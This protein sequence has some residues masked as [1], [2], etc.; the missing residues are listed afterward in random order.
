MRAA[1]AGQVLVVLND[2]IHLAQYV[3]K[4]D[5]QLPG[6]FRSHPGPLGQ[7][8]GGAALL[9]YAPPPP[10]A[11]LAPGKEAAQA[12]QHRPTAHPAWL[13][14]PQYGHLPPAALARR[15]AIWPLTMDGQAPPEALLSQLDGLVL[16]GSGTGSLPA[17][18][19]EALAGPASD[20]G[21]AVDGCTSSR[22]GRQVEQAGSGGSGHRSPWT[23]RLPI[24]I[25]S[26]CTWGSNHDDFC[27]KGSRAKYEGRGF[28]LGGGYEQLNPL[29]ARVL[30]ALRLAAFGHA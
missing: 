28:V 3:F 18:V 2:S 26:R 29:Q 23:A 19:V 8:R 15:V 1:A 10:P 30:L 20:G 25:S 21:S 16:A 24:V 4:A 13:P 7:L 12:R 9:Y 5:S 6:A 14:H 27:Y 17:S 22:G 11:P